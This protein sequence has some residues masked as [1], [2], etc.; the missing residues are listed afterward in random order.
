MKFRKNLVEIKR[1]FGEFK[2][3]VNLK[4][5]FLIVI[6]TC[7]SWLDL[8]AVWCEL[9]IIVH[10]LVE[11][12]RTP[13]ILSIVIQI[14]QIGSLV[15]LLLKFFLPRIFTYR[16]CIYFIL[17]IGEVSCILIALFWNRK[18]I[19][20][21]QIISLPLFIL[22]FSF[23]LLGNSHHFYILIYTVYIFKVFYV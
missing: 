5:F 18:V 6:F 14:A 20:F 12:W 21:D 3:Q 16:N 8:T 17:V 11:G 23:A 1:K 13:S 19:V 22:N 7:A 15:Y 9:P 4:V 2:R 10:E